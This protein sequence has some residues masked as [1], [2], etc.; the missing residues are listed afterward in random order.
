MKNLILAVAVFGMITA[1]SCKNESSNSVGKET[2]QTLEDAG[3]EALNPDEGIADITSAEQEAMEVPEFSNSDVQNFANEYSKYFEELL[4]TTKSGDTEKIQELTK[5]G[6]DWAKKES[7]ITQNMN[8]EDSQKWTEWTNKL[9][10]LVNG[11]E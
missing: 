9:R 4:K 11:G 10:D 2:Q 1:T 6:V 7:A 8:A 5:Q 3:Q